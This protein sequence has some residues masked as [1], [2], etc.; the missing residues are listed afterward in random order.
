MQRVIE[1]MVTSPRENEYYHVRLF[2]D[3]GE[4]GTYVLKVYQVDE[5]RANK[6]FGPIQEANI[7]G[8]TNSS[9][10]NKA[11][12]LFFKTVKEYADGVK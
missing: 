2:D 6:L 5:N 11:F 3:T 1:A 10:R 12:E 4:T 7:E 9:K 8:R